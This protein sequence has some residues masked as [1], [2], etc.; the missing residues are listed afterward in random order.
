M[1][2]L[3]AKYDLLMLADSTFYLCFLEDIEKPDILLKMLSTFKFIVPPLVFEEVRVCKNY[4][5]MRGVNTVIILYSEMNLGE[6][7]KPFFSTEEVKK[8][9]AEV[10]ALAYLLHESNKI[11]NFILDEQDAR[12]FVTNNLPH[13]CKKM[14]GTVGFIGECHC[15]F[16]ILLKDHALAILQ[17]IRNSRFRVTDKILNNVKQEIEGC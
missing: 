12:N 17:D 2:I 6:V 11:H 9:E 13:L 1:I 4:K 8:G 7:L 5:H 3:F 14:I 16:R 10:I 15:N